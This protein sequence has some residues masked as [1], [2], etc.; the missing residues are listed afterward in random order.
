MT[1]FS[2][3]HDVSVVLLYLFSCGVLPL[4]SYWGL[5]CDHGLDYLDNRVWPR[6]YVNNKTKPVSGERTHDVCR[7]FGTSAVRSCQMCHTSHI[8]HHIDHDLDHHTQIA[9]LRSQMLSK[10]QII[11]IQQGQDVRN[12]RVLRAHPK[13]LTVSTSRTSYK[14]RILLPRNIYMMI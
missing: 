11:H 8:T 5:S 13:T 2:Y 12:S 1:C 10:S 7:L 14:S 9:Q 6:L 4:Q 3:Y